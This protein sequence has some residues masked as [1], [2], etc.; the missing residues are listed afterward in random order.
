[1]ISANRYINEM[2]SS[3]RLTWATAI[4]AINNL[5]FHKKAVHCVGWT[6]TSASHTHT[7]HLIDFLILNSTSL[8]QNSFVFYFINPKLLLDF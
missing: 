4:L 1:M 3:R 2:V 7:E 6:S 5:L 8:I